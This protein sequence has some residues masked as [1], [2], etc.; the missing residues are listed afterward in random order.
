[1]PRATVWALLVGCVGLLMVTGCQ[2]QETANANYKALAAR[3]KALSDRMAVMEEKQVEIAVLQP[4][5]DATSDMSIAPPPAQ[6]QTVARLSGSQV[7]SGR[8]R[9]DIS[10]SGKAELDRVAMRLNT[11]LAAGAVVIEGHTDTDPIRKLKSRYNDNYEL[12][13][14]RAQSV[15]DYLTPP[16]ATGG[17]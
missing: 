9:A 7:S 1:M 6:P 16:E 5:R 17:S 12:G 14:A 4:S 2:S 3:D 13:R 8:W 11:E 15:A 10:S